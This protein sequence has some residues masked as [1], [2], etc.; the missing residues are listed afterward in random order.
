MLTFPLGNGENL[1]VVEPGNVQRLKEGRPLKL[2][3]GGMLCFTP[4]LA[5]FLKELGV[6]LELP[7]PHERIEKGIHVSADDL[8]EALSKC[9]KLPEVIR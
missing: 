5:A 9:Q 2:P 4:D 8:V 7:R 6:P 3:A 1:Y